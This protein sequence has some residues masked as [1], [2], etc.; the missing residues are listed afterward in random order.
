M[1]D[2]ITENYYKNGDIDGRPEVRLPTEIK[3]MEFFNAIK[4]TI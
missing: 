2:F 3:D 1:Y 4:H